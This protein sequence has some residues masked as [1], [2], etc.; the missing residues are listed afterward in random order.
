MRRLTVRLNEQDWA[1]AHAY[2]EDRR[3]PL[4]ILARSALMSAIKRDLSRSNVWAH[5]DKV[6]DQRLSDALA[7]R[8]ASAEGLSD[9]D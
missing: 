3:V 1:L 7:G 8:S 2:A 6:I 4:A 5:L 9:R